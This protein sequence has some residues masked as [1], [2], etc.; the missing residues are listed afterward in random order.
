MVEL[1]GRAYVLCAICAAD[2]AV[3]A[4]RAGEDAGDFAPLVQLHA[5]MKR[6]V[7]TTKAKVDAKILWDGKA[8]RDE[9]HAKI[10]FGILDRELMMARGKDVS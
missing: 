5:D 1:N 10:A 3:R 7:E 2:T 4:F 8:L 6:A 9:R